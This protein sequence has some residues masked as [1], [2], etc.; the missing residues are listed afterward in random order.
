MSI[1]TSDI[2]TAI[3]KQIQPL[4]I[5]LNAYERTSLES[6]IA[7]ITSKESDNYKLAALVK[8]YEQC[9]LDTDQRKDIYSKIQELI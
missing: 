6:I 9:V 7:D 8:L 2:I 5:P 1:I 3:G 4:D